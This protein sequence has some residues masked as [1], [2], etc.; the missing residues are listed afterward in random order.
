MNASLQL[1]TGEFM[2]ET[3]E[4]V[5]SSNRCNLGIRGI[6]VMETR[7]TF[8]LR[9]NRK[10]VIQKKG[11]DFKIKGKNGNFQVLRGDLIALRP[12]NRIKEIRRIEKML[13]GRKQ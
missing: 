4:V 13:G 8:V 7:N 10:Y 3:L 6:V 12:E 2:G 11:T 1:H 5:R 9:N